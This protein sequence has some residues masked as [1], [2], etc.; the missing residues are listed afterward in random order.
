MIFLLSEPEIEIGMAALG[1]AP[2]VGI[3]GLLNTV[4]LKRNSYTRMLYTDH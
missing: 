1:Y 2:A 3:D 4:T